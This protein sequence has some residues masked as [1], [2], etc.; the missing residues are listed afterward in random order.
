MEKTT[1]E[2]IL[3]TWLFASGHM[4]KIILEGKEATKDQYCPNWSTMVDDKVILTFQQIRKSLPINKP[5]L[6]PVG[7]HQNT[8][9]TYKMRIPFRQN[10]PHRLCINKGDKAKH[11]LLLAGDAYILNWPIFATNQRLKIKT[12]WTKRQGIWKFKIRT[13]ITV[14]RHP[15]LK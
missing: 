6:F 10:M 15:Y 4:D 3:F 11:P 7:L 9:P 13:P 1:H 14:L 8:S 12:L 5:R 2:S